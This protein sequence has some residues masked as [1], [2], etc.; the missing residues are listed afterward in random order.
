MRQRIQGNEKRVP[1]QFGHKLDTH[2]FCRVAGVP[3]PRL[4][5]KFDH[6]SEIELA[7]LPKEFVLK[8]SYSSTSQGVMVFKREGFDSCFDAMSGAMVSVDMIRDTQSRIFS[9][10]TG[11]NKVTIVE[12]RVVDPFGKAIPKDYKFLGFQGEIG[13]IIAIERIGKRMK[14]SYFDGQFRPVVDRRVVFNPK[15]AERVDAQLPQNW[16]RL[17]NVA[18]RISHAVPTPCARID[19]FDALDGPVLGE[20]TLT[21]GSFYFPGG[22]RLSSA[23]DARL[24]QLWGDAER[25]LWG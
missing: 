8:P 19:L 12:E 21:P 5:R 2:E 25:R 15:I 24:G 16:E 4:L 23:E 18:R 7:G 20:V 11:K 6:P 9:K 14:M 3:V 22:H 1:Y 10:S 13:M 17:L